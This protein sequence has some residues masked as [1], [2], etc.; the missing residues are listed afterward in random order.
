MNQF[1]LTVNCFTLLKMHQYVLD[2]YLVVRY[3]SYN[4][5][6]SYGNA[7]CKVSRCIAVPLLLIRG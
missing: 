6:Q 5:V 2:M 1:V 4:N 3:T 7:F